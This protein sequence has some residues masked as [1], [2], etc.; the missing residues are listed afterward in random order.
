MTTTTTT[1][2]SSRLTKVRLLVLAVVV[3]VAGLVVWRVVGQDATVPYDDPQS[4]GLITLCSA[5]GEPVTEGSVEDRPFADFA[6]GE[7]ALPSE[8]DPTGAVASLFA[9]QPRETIA[10][11]EFSGTTLTAAQ[12]LADPGRPA[13][14]VT[15]DVWSV[16]DFVTA[17]PAS[18]DGYVQLRIYLGTPAAGTLTENAYDTADLRVDGDRWELV[19]GG[20]ASCADVS[21]LVK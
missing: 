7:T 14:R 2:K 13:V 10:A 1:S 5:D 15:E 12:E 20:S 21:A 8:L 3:G 9:Y 19:R 16:D 18:Y 6:V 4:T 11:D 17:F